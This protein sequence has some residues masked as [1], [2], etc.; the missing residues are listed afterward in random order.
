MDVAAT[1]FQLCLA[2]SSPESLHHREADA[3]LSV[4][5][6]AEL[7]DGTIAVLRMSNRC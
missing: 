3:P 2:R 1:Y 6:S 5:K 7:C 4:I